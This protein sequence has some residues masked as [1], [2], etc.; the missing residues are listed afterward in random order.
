[1]QAQVDEG[2]QV[3]QNHVA[4]QLQQ[5]QLASQQEGQNISFQEGLD[6][7]PLHKFPF[8]IPKSNSNLS[9]FG[10]VAWGRVDCGAGILIPRQTDYEGALLGS[11]QLQLKLIHLRLK[12]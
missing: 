8:C 2:V 5:K 6:V 3:V 1:M 7:F 11:V 9:V 12:Q 4:H 10:K